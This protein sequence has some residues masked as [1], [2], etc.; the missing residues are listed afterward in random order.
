[1]LTVGAQRHEF[2]SHWVLAAMLKAGS[3]GEVDAGNS[4]G[5]DG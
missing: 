3:G 2:E 1:M 5:R 4:P